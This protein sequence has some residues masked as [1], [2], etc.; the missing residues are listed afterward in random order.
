MSREFEAIA[1]PVNRTAVQQV[2]LMTRERRRLTANFRALMPVGV[3]IT[4][5]QWDMEVP[6]DVAMSAGQIVGSRTSVLIEA[7]QEGGGAE[8]RC[9]V[10]LSTGEVLAQYFVVLVGSGPVFRDSGGMAGAS[11]IVV[12]A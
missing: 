6:G 2:D 9:Q 5:A 3:T 7:Q 8:I 4:R 10:T 12:T 1:S 11:Q